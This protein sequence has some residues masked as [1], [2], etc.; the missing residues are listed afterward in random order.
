MYRP[1]GMVT[2]VPALMMSLDPSVTL[3]S[4]VRVID[5]DHVSVPEM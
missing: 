4:P 3:T 5:P 1:C 2:V